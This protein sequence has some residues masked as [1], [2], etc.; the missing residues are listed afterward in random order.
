M[1]LINEEHIPFGKIG[2]Q[3][4]QIGSLFNGRT[5]R[6]TQ[7]SPHGTGQNVGN[8]GLSQTRGAAQENMIQRLFTAQRR[9]NSDLQPLLHL[10]LASEIGKSS[11]PQ[12]HLQGG[13]RLVQ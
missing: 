10:G 9:L 7:G 12:R 11:R 2:E 13:I 5:A 8:G 4:R 1:N 3:T 6:G